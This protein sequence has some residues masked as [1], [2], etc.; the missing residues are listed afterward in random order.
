MEGQEGEEHP[1]CFAAV[2]QS[3]LDRGDTS[4]LLDA[5]F[6][7]G[8]LYE[9]RSASDQ[10]VFPIVGRKKLACLDTYSPLGLDIDVDLWG[11]TLSIW[12]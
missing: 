3:L 10:T 1:H 9:R 4:L 11:I 12:R 8:N 2:N 7:L 5:L 6:H